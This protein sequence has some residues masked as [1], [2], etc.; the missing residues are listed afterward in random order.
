MRECILC[1]ENKPLD[2]GV[3][4]CKPACGV[5][6]GKSSAKSSPSPH[7]T[8]S[9][10]FDKYVLREAT[11]C[12]KTCIMCPWAT[13]SQAGDGKCIKCQSPPF[14][15]NVIAAQVSKAT[16]DAYMRAKAQAV[17]AGAERRAQ[18][19]LKR[20]LEKVVKM[21]DEKRRIYS[22]RKHILDNLLNDMCPR[23]HRGIVPPTFDGDD[24]ECF[25]LFCQHADCECSFCAW[26]FKDCGEDAH[27][28]V[29]TCEYNLEEKKELYSSM[30]NFKLARVF[31]LTRAV[32]AYLSE[33]KEDIAEKVVR[34]CANE[35][36]DVGLE[37]LVDEYTEPVGR[38]A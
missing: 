2:Q 8:C 30:A 18:A 6:D 16:F 4:C 26:C 28:H 12:R 21:A 33:M 23:C 5:V 29:A 35:L 36:I 22:A 38:L 20:E 37:D 9:G 15:D 7:F 17:E 34:E 10:C 27:R 13:L 32:R 11:D 3:Q 14:A 24:G 31:R 19:E 1:S 25:A